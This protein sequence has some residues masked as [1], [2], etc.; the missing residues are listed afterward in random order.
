MLVVLLF[1]IGL[2]S[3]VI[4]PNLFISVFITIGLLTIYA[5]K[6]VSFTTNTFSTFISCST[7]YFSHLSTSSTIKNCTQMSSY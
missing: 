4:F 3:F 6:I 5:L 1:V 7:D 2:L